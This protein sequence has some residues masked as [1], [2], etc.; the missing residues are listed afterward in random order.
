MKVRC[1]QWKH[2]WEWTWEFCLCRHCWLRTQGAIIKVLIC[3]AP[4]EEFLPVISQDEGDL[5]LPSPCPPWSWCSPRRHICPAP[6][7]GEHHLHLGRPGG[8]HRGGRQD[9]GGAKERPLQQHIDLQ[10]QEHS[11]RQ[12]LPP[13][14]AGCHSSPHPAWPPCRWSSG[15]PTP[16]SALT[17][18][19]MTQLG[20]DLFVIRSPHSCILWPFVVKPDNWLQVKV[21]FGGKIDYPM[22]PQH[23]LLFL[24]F[25][26]YIQGK[27]TEESINEFKAKPLVLV[28]YELD[29]EYGW[30]L[31]TAIEVI[32]KEHCT[33][34]T[35]T[36]FLSSTIPLSY[37]P[38][39][40]NHCSI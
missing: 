8:H 26:M 4:A 39:R 23:S 30:I 20:P 25:V 21:L 13:V 32:L 3:F 35:H 6:H 10:V 31:A 37:W 19:H 17:A 14:P 12:A 36:L 11:L 33:I 28:V 40:L 7:Q 16:P 15:T 22:L 2:G 24:H 5:H 27:M 29:P 34:K 18:A 1:H 9:D 38:N